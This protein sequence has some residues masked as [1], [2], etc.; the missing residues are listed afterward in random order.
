MTTQKTEPSSKMNTINAL[1]LEGVARSDNIARLLHAESMDSGDYC[2][3]TQYAASPTG[4]RIY[5]DSFFVDGQHLHLDPPLSF[6][7]TL[8]SEAAMLELHGESAYRDI[9]V[10]GDTLTH[11]VEILQME[12]L[13]ILWEDCIDQ[14][15]GVLSSRARQMAVDFR[16]RVV[17]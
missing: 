7:I 8:A 15:D 2:Y 4:H 12:V 1:C 9:L 6:I 11:A 5:I 14:D 16:M 17:G 10:Y 13:P 3:A